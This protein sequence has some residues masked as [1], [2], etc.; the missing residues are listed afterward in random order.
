MSQGKIFVGVG[1]WTFEPWRG[2]FYPKGLPARRELEDMSSRLTSVEVNGTYYRLQTPS[3][4]A[5]WHDETPEGFVFALKGSRYI[6]NRKNL[7]DAGESI[8]RFMAS[9]LTELKEKLGP[10]NWQLAP[11]KKFDAEEFGAFLALLPKSLDGRFLRHAVE[12]RHPS[13][14]VPEAVAI[15]REHG[16]A[17]VAAGDCEYPQIADA[18]APFVYARIMGTIEDE[19][20]GYSEPALDAW[21]ERA[22][23]WASGKQ[24]DGLETIGK[25]PGPSEPRDV[26]LYV[27]SGAKALNPLAAEALIERLK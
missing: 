21:A 25:E 13:F 18:T 10:L 6:T 11:T 7:A 12:V 3:T 5:K 26:Y 9:G 14:R 2:S 17:L 19:R 16:V 27:I 15:A 8:E 1:G 22:R 4:F 24:P 20:L 23:A